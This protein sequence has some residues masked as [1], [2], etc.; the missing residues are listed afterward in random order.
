MSAAAGA[1]C[2]PRRLFY[3]AED[4][5]PGPLAVVCTLVVAFCSAVTQGHECLRSSGIRALRERVG[6]REF[7]FSKARWEHSA[8]L[9][10]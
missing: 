10:S 6:I 2:S 4:R 5:V 1:L 7:H 3:G 9:C 8:S